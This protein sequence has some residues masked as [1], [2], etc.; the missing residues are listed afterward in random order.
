MPNPRRN[1][2][3]YVNVVILGQLAQCE[4]DSEFNWC[5]HHYHQNKTTQPSP[6]SMA[7]SR[8]SLR[9]RLVTLCTSLLCGHNHC[10]FVEPFHFP[11]WK[12]SSCLKSNHQLLLVCFFSMNS[13]VVIRVVRQHSFHRIKK[14]YFLLSLF[15]IT[16]LGHNQRNRIT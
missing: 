10:L 9:V 12:F 11:K 7:P 15:L 1:K 4:W 2:Y 5:H 6:Q 16:I 14:H 13:T 3:K 8:P